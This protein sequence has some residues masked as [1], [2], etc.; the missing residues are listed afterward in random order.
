MLYQVGF[1]YYIITIVLFC[2]LI[3]HFFFLFLDNLGGDKS[4][5][6]YFFS[7]LG[8]LK[9]S[10]EMFLTSLSCLFS[11]SM[12]GIVK[13]SPLSL[14]I[15]FH[16]LL[17]EKSTGPRS[18]TTPAIWGASSALVKIS[19]SFFSFG[20]EFFSSMSSSMI[21]TLKNTYQNLC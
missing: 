7:C 17:S 2:F 19:N 12:L 8:G 11:L 6:K 4:S 16:L 3:C 20:L 18:S 14:A 1:P 10:S 13:S 5:S 21:F 15:I 9:S